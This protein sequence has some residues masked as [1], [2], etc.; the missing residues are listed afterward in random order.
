MALQNAP[1][2]Q[3]EIESIELEPVRVRVQ[4]DGSMDSNN[5]AKYLNRATKTLAMWRMQGTGPE[6]TKRGGRVIY[7]MNR[8]DTYIEEE[9]TA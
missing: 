2:R 3:A 6:W 9:E 7:Y 5:A 8:L 1:A 4:P